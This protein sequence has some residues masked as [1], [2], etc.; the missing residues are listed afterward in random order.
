MSSIKDL[1]HKG[2]LGRSVTDAERTA[3][4]AKEIA[5]QEK[6]YQ[7]EKN[8]HLRALRLERDRLSSNMH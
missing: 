3:I 4:H 8:A 1:T 2:M 6:A 7:D 5:L